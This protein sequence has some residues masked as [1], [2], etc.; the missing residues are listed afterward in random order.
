[1]AMAEGKNI[2]SGVI[3]IPA[4]SSKLAKIFLGIF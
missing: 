1:M 4:T 2:Y 3:S